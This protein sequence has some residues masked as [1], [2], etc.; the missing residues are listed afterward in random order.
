MRS[1]EQVKFSLPTSFEKI[2]SGVKQQAQIKGLDKGSTKTAIVERASSVH[3]ASLTTKR[4]P[5]IKN[6]VH[7]FELEAKALKKSWEGNMEVKNQ[8]YSKL[9][10]T[11]QDSKPEFQSSS[12][13]KYTTYWY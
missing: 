6:I 7:G 2:A 1:L 4:L 13:C 11:K 8:D 5:V 3:G 9:K 10:A 12:V